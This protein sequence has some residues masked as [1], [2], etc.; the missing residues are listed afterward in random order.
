MKR[1]FYVLPCIIMCSFYGNAQEEHGQKIQDTVSR[2]PIALD[3]VQVAAVRV[4]PDM[5]LSFSNISKEEIAPRNL[6]QD[7]PILLNYL[8]AVVTTSDAGAGVGYTGI[9]IRGSDATRVNVTIN[10]IPYNDAESQ[11]TFWVDLPD[12]ASSV[13]NLQL[14]RGV[15]T[16]TNGAGAF[17]ASLHLLTDAVSDSAC[18]ELSNA[19]GSFH[20]RKH[21]LKFGTGRLNEHLELSGRVSLIASDGYIDRASSDL[22]SYFFQGTYSDERSAF[23]A[24]LFG[25]REITYQAWNGIDAETLQNDRTFNPSGMYEDEEGTIRFY[26]NEIDDYRQDHV[27]GHWNQIWNTDWT[28]HLALHYTHGSGFFEQYREDEAFEDY[29]LQPINIENETIST[30]DLIRRRWLDNDFYGTVFSVTYD[31][32]TLR[33]TLGGAWN[34]YEGDHFGEV[35]WARYA[36]DSEIRDR[37]YENTGEKTDFNVFAKVAYDLNEKWKLFGDLQYRRVGYKVLGPNS[38][39]VL[40]DIDETY[41]F[42]NPKVGWSYKIDAANG[43]Y[44]SYAVAHREPNRTDFE[45]GSP[46][47]EQLHDIEL[48]WRYHTVKSRI[49]TNLYYMYYTDQLVLTGEIDDVGTPIRA[50]SGSSYRLGWEADAVLQLSDRWTVRPNVALSINRNIDFVFQRDGD[51]EALGNTHISYAPGI[52]AANI[53]TCQPAERVQI[54][55]LSKYVGPQYMGN[56]DAETS[57]LEGYF[58]SD[59]NIKYEIIFRKIFSS[60]IFNALINNVFDTKYV[61]NGYYYTFDADNGDGTVTTLDGAGYYPQAGIN[62]LLG[63]TLK[64]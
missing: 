57:R 62:F 37:Y 20:T 18:A 27:Q 29:G 38:D 2:K 52:V 34:R 56:I 10:G 54:S 21:T 58:T 49:N 60:V 3:E 1:F 50:N 5:P 17:G 25:G 11:G 61:S 59:L 51:P 23:K 9:R 4:Y 46:R 43:L 36:S 8:P 47:P 15:G 12:F 26:D 53:L 22:K 6:G 28:T 44:F 14:Q 31:K 39:L 7:I 55:F 30:T 19:F 48:G 16:S 63:V 13:E 35:I 64:L 33:L 40:L 42:F 24:L 41:H 45:N 32:E